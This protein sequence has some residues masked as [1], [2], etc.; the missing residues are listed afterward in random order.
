MFGKL[1]R[2]TTIY[3]MKPKLPDLGFALT[4]ALA[5]SRDVEIDGL[6]KVM[7]PEAVPKKIGS[8]DE[9]PSR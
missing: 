7:R 5:T 2:A 4:L 3:R 9:A 8:L 1:F 6:G